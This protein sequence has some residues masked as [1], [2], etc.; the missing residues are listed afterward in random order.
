MTQSI[1]NKAPKKPIAMPAKPAVPVARAVRTPTHDEISER[2]R[3]LWE[4]K[5]CP[6]GQDEEI[7]LEAEA[8]LKKG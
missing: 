7:W 3:K 2:A 8:Q 4:A 5:G 6:A 1:L